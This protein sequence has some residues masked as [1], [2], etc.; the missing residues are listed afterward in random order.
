MD[1]VVD[2]FYLFMTTRTRYKY[3]TW[4]SCGQVVASDAPCKIDNWQEMIV[5]VKLD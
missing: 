5:K 3:Y 4:P 1:S 2:R